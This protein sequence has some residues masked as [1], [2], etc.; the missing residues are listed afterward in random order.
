MRHFCTTLGKWLLI[1]AMFSAFGG[2]WV[3]LQS[4]A[5]TSMAFSNAKHANLTQ[6][7]EKTFDGQHPCELCKRI[8]KARQSEKKQ[9]PQ[10]A[11]TKITFFYETRVIALV[12]PRDC[13]QQ[14]VDDTF[15]GNRPHRPIL[16]P[17][18]ATLS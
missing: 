12:S 5:W 4:V 2:H 14:Q 13:W 9:D 15:A 1:A 11:I 10:I 6:A 7:L 18:R 8:E 17:P 3:L 16:Q